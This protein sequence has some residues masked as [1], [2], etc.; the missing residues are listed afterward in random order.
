ME[1]TEPLEVDPQLPTTHRKREAEEWALVLE[2]EGVAVRVV[3]GESGFTVA[4][5]AADAARAATSLASWKSERAL[6]PPSPEPHATFAP[7][8]RLEILLAVACALALV[9]FHLGLDRSGRLDEFI[10][11]G[12]N[13]AVLVIAGD[14]YRTVTALSLHAD[15]AHAVG[16]GLF[17]A[18][19]L[20][21]LSGRLGLG[22]A[23]ACF[24]ATGALGNF[25]DALYYGSGHR[26][27]G[28]ST[29]V[30]GLVGV[31]AGL[32]AWRRHRI[33]TRNR[34][35]WV[36]LGAGLAIVAMLGGAGPKIDL[37]AHLF[38]L[39][40][41]SLAGIA[42]A[43]PLANQPRPGLVAQALAAAG[44]VLGIALAWQW[45]AS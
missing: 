24:L 9:A 23:L 45:A 36:A 16:N 13:Q 17:G 11:R 43:I 3:R 4:V 10:S 18:F 41:G 22:L 19:F 34:G 28:A 29:G 14:L 38:G 2:A 32:A 26:S 33:A 30:F 31:L 35:A 8:S 42:L 40:A 25:A 37:A 7:A 5:P 27:I 6:P 12:E 20:S 39:G 15:L 1:S 44:S 21:I